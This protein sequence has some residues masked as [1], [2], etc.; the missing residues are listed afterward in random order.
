[1]TEH[2][3]GCRPRRAELGRPNAH[4]P[5]PLP[6]A[7]LTLKDILHIAAPRSAS[8]S[9]PPPSSS[10]PLRV[11][12]RR[13]APRRA[14]AA[15]GR[16]GAGAS[17]PHG[18]RLVSFWLLFPFKGFFFWGG[19]VRGALGITLVVVVVVIFILIL[20]ISGHGYPAATRTP[21]S[22]SSTPRSKTP[23]WGPAL[24][25][26]RFR[27]IYIEIEPPLLRNSTETGGNP[28]P[29]HPRPS[30]VTELMPPPWHPFC[31]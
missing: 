20:K 29:P 24:L 4:P 16:G 19:G 13:S 7:R 17:L 10:A 8:S 31:I 18:F 14:G 6:G 21:C 12:P 1:M 2:F 27:P 28:G 30:L 26:R 9:P 15:R 11:P 23:R 3:T 22:S 25:G 5:A